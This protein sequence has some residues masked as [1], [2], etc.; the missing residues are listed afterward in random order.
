M[1]DAKRNKL[2]GCSN[3]R[4]QKLIEL[5]NSDRKEKAKNLLSMLQKDIFLEIVN[6]YNN[7]K[8]CEY[9]IGVTS[10]FLAERL[11]IQEKTITEE[12]MVIEEKCFLIG[13]PETYWA[14]LFDREPVYLEK[15]KL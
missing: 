12:L 9:I 4:K 1:S 15:K 5:V 13:E 6:L 7:G 14:T 8:N 2:T 10:D 3:Q 11:K